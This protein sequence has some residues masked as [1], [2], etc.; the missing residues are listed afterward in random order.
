MIVALDPELAMFVDVSAVDC[1]EV[2]V[3]GGVAEFGGLASGEG[4]DLVDWVE[5]M[6]NLVCYGLGSNLAAGVLAWAAPLASCPG[7][8]P[9]QE[10]RCPPRPAAP[11]PAER[12]ASSLAPAA[13]G[14]AG[15]P[16]APFAGA[17]ATTFV[18][19]SRQL[20]VF[21]GSLSTLAPERHPSLAQPCPGPPAAPG[22][23][24]SPPPP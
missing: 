15:A 7:P 12:A 1:A 13:P 6:L 4:V 10:H 2:A 5:G 21:R 17:S 22:R 8:V 18:C 3:A 16:C 9:S 24:R 23:G 19:A 20:A 11:P 14:G